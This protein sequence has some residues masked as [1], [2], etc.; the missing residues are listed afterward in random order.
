MT[1]R[2]IAVSETLRSRRLECGLELPHV[3]QVL[4]IRQA[5][6][7]A[8]ED[9]RFDQLPGPAYAVGFVRSY[10]A[11]LGLDAE[12][13][14]LRFKAEATELSRRPHLNFP[15]PIRDSRV[16]TGPV[17]IICLLLALLTY[18]G[19]HYFSAKP[20]DPLA[21]MVPA[22]PERLRNLLKS[23]TQSAERATT[24]TATPTETVPAPPAS[25]TEPS[26]PNDGE[27]APPAAAAPQP[28]AGA[29]AS[30]PT[31]EADGVPPV[32]AQPG[33]PAPAAA[34]PAVP[35]LAQPPVGSEPAKTTAEGS[36]GAPQSEARIVLHATSDSWI[37]VRDRQSNLIFTRV[38]KAGER[39]YVPNQAGLSLVAG[40]AGGLDISVDGTEI[41]HIGEAGRVARNV[42]LDPDRLLGT[43]SHAN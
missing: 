21:D 41:P 40:N 34:L 42:A 20:S 29:V 5:I 35:D 43:T 38:L 30:P 4:R 16:P 39:Y 9:G 22:V 1:P 15:L 3:A 23:P 2:R 25:A 10:A 31:N 37:Q 26:G 14:V 32:Q 19:W 28:Q 33:T 12:A 24:L 18:A 11:Y 17:L 13:I 8:I 7:A 27:Q 6:L 36:Y